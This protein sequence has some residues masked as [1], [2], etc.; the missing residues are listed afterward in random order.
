VLERQIEEG[1]A[2][3]RQVEDE[4]SEPGAWSTP[5]RIARSSARHREAK[6]AVERLYEQLEQIAG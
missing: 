6:A 2:A 5:A 1:E 4:L 3:L